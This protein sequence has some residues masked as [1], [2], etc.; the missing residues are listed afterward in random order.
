VLQLSPMLLDGEKQTHTLI[1]IGPNLKTYQ[2]KQTIT[3]DKYGV[4]NKVDNDVSQVKLPAAIWTERMME[5]AKK[6]VRSEW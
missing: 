2:I 4:S 3:V 1:G 5:I 6:G